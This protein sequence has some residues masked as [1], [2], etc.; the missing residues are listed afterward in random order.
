MTLTTGRLLKWS[1]C[2]KHESRS[3][4][5]LPNRQTLQH[6]WVPPSHF[7]LKQ[8]QRLV[9]LFWELKT[10]SKWKL[11]LDYGWKYIKYYCQVSQKGC[12]AVRNL[13]TLLKDSSQGWVL[14]LKRMTC[15]LRTDLKLSWYLSVSHECMYDI[16][17]VRDSWSPKWNLSGLY[18]TPDKNGISKLDNQTLNTECSTVEIPEM[19]LGKQTVLV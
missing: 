1:W 16:W 13:T 9:D 8:S 3:L 15:Y 2:S 14:Q 7:F 6:E 11:V 17:A 4:E 10:W 12:R 18:Q 19:M 5:K